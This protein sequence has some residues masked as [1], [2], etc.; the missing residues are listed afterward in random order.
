MGIEE[1]YTTSGSGPSSS[2]LDFFNVNKLHTSSCPQ[3]PKLSTCY[4]FTTMVN[5]Y[6]LSLWASMG[7]NPSF[8]LLLLSHVL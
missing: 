6:S 4:A 2:L 3:G 1:D 8:S 7:I 5:G